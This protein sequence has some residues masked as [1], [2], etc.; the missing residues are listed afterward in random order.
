LKQNKWLSVKTARAKGVYV[1]AVLSTPQ[2]SVETLI[3][4]R[5][6]K[7]VRISRN[8]RV[9]FRA[10]H[11]PPISISL[12]EIYALAKKRE[13]LLENMARDFI[14]R[15]VRGRPS[16]AMPERLAELIRARMCGSPAPV[17]TIAGSGNHGLFLGLPLYELYQKQGE[18]VLPAVVFA[19]LTEILMTGGKK[20]ISDDCG[21]A[22]K[23]APALAAGLA[24]A[25]GLNLEPIER[26]MK[27][28]QR[29]MAKL[30]CHGALASCGGKAS[31]AYG[32]VHQQVKRLASGSKE[33]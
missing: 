24:Y 18:S 2:E 21:L 23:A 11:P 20:R 3:Q 32:V 16:L 6:H 26:L 7:I 33:A 14:Q 27:S 9:I 10:N 13:V 29:A 28:V 31:L 12:K 22:V 4:G 15:Q 30:K 5:H 1:K 25:Q 8:G 17:M 19:L